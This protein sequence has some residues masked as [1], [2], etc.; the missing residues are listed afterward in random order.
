MKGRCASRDSSGAELNA[1]IGIDLGYELERIVK[2][3]NLNQVS[4]PWRAWRDIFTH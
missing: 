1:F 3:L 2:Q 4:P